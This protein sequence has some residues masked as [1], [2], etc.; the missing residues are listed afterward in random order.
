MPA[1]GNVDVDTYLGTDGRQDAVVRREGQHH[2]PARRATNGKLTKIGERAGGV[3]VRQGGSQGSGV[4]DE[5]AF[6]AGQR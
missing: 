3:S 2:P 4:D 1:P 6:L 5:V